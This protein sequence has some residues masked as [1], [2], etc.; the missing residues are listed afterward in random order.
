MLQS[1]RRGFLKTAGAGVA[2][3]STLAGCLGDLGGS[4][5][6]GGGLSIE[7]A[8]PIASTNDVNWWYGVREIA[9]E[10]YGLDA[11]ATVMQGGRDIMLQ[12]T[13]SG[14]VDGFRESPTSIMQLI[15]QGKDIKYIATDN[16]GTQYVLMGNPGFET[17][18]DVVE[19][20]ARIGMASSITG[21]SGFQVVATLMAEGVIDSVDEV[22]D[23]FVQ[24]GYSSDRLA[25]LVNGDIDVS[26]QLYTQWVGSREDHPDL[27][28]II[29]MAD[30]LTDWATYG[31]IALPEEIEQNR[32]AY[33]AMFKGIQ[34]AND[35]I[36]N[37]YNL[38]RDLV[39]KY[40]TE[41]P[42][43]NVLQ[44]AYEL[45]VDMNYWKTPLTTSQST[46]DFQ[47]NVMR[48]L[49]MLENQ[50]THDQVVDNSAAQ[51]AADELSG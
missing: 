41:P 43:E 13:L 7:L 22:A 28:L 5:G 42:N 33:V 11:E 4:T 17:L 25:A 34:Q 29:R 24:I 31:W 27:N 44:T 39:N 6:S 1:S 48:Q 46:I 21:L 49:G 20:E 45:F 12:S 40:V 19:K 36:S 35:E 16:A 51:A 37:D 14:Q 50:L 8:V 23:Q 47:V 15:D 2:I 38:Y 10:E 32:D 9:V 26:P 30:A 3:S 18:E